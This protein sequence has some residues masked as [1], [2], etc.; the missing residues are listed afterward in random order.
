MPKFKI[1]KKVVNEGPRVFLIRHG[2]T[3]LNASGDGAVDRIRGWVNVPLNDEGIQDAKNARDTLEG[4]VH[5][6]NQF[7]VSNL[8][9]TEDTAKIVNQFFKAPMTETVCL[10]PW[11]LGILQGQETDKVKSRMKYYADNP[12]EV[13]ED[14]ESFNNFKKR[15]IS[16]LQ[17]IIGEANRDNSVIVLVT[18]FRNVKMAQAWIEKGMPAS[19]EVDESVLSKQD[20]EPGQVCEIPIKDNK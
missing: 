1:I 15:Y 18:H 8:D 12:D 17:R 13:V 6:V 14:G 7:Y 5:K 10:R 11:N 9:R 4:L 2:H 16:F 20:I 3:A 19:M